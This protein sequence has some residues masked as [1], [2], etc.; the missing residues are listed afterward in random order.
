[1]QGFE[2]VHQPRP[3]LL[4]PAG[5]IGV[6]IAFLDAS[7]KQGVVLEV[8]LLL[9]SAHAHIADENGHTILSTPAGIWYPAGIPSICCATEQ[10][11]PP[12]AALFSPP[13]VKP[14]LIH[15]AI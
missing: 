1:M 13:G 15:K 12:T 3:G 10:G 14:R 9:A 4:R 6:E 7:S 5:H 2:T 11:P 8:E